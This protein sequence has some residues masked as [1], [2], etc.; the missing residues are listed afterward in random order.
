MQEIR[1][2][3][4]MTYLGFWRGGDGWVK[5]VKFFGRFKFSEEFI[6]FYCLCKTT[7]DGGLRKM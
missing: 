7:V 2:L 6:E 5:E 1:N 3:L 4:F